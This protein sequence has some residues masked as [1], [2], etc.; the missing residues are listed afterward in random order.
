MKKSFY[1]IHCFHSKGA[2]IEEEIVL[3]SSSGKRNS[4]SSS[5]PELNAL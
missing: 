1:M 4:I 5:W 3:I 2:H